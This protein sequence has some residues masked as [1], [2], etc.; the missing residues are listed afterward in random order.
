MQIVFC[1]IITLIAINYSLFFVFFVCIAGGTWRFCVAVSNF[2]V[3]AKNMTGPGWLSVATAGA[4]V[5]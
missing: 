1:S 4:S 2:L 5:G 3:T